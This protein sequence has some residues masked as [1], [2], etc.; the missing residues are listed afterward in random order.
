MNKDKFVKRVMEIS[1]IENKHFV[2][3]GIQIVFSLLNH[4]LQ[5]NEAHHVNEQLPTELKKMWNCDVWITNYFK[6]SG[7]RL[8][9]RHKAQFLSLVENELIRDHI[10]I[11]AEAITK[12]VLH[13]LKE[14]IS[15]GESLDIAASLPEE[16]KEY[17]RA[18]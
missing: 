6:M 14:Q 17:Y 16:L 4:R 10:P 7:K 12:A 8:M 11:N 13:T 5:E 1:G 9:Y 2:E 18:A 3:R 15:I